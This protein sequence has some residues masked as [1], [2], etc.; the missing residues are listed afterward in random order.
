MVFVRPIPNRNV[1]AH[2]AKYIRR[3]GIG[4]V[5]YMSTNMT[6]PPIIIKAAQQAAPSLSMTTFIPFNTVHHK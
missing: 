1:V 5:G 3:S 2:P 4:V 6:A